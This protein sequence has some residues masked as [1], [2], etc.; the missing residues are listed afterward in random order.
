MPGYGLIGGDHEFF[1]DSVGNVALGPNDV[2]RYALEIK[3]NLRLGQIEIQVPSGSA[4]FIH[5]ERQRLHQFELIHKI[6]ITLQMLR[7]LV[8]QDPP[9]G[10]VG[11]PLTA[12]NHR[13]E[14][15]AADD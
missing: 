12:T 3:D 4:A 15:A 8:H 14:E 5:Q 1:N 10:G 2:F 7:V 6:P 9:H 11:H 13:V